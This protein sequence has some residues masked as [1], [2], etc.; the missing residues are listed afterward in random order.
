MENRIRAL[1]LLAIASLV[2]CDQ[3]VVE[4]NTTTEQ[5]AHGDEPTL[6]ATPAIPCDPDDGGLTLPGGFCAVVVHD[7]TT[8]A[9]DPAQA[10]HIVVTPNGDVF[11]ALQSDG[12][13]V[14]ALRDTD[15]DGKAD[16]TALFGSGPGHGLAYHEPYL[17]FAPN[18]RVE[19]YLLSSESLTPVSGPEVIVSEMPDTGD[20]VTK[21]IAV[22]DHGSLFVNLGS[23]SD[24]CQEVNRQPA[25]I[26]VDPCPE[27]PTRSGIWRYDA[28][29]PG[30]VHSPDNRYLTGTR[31]I[32]A[33]ALNPSDGGLYGVQHGRDNL[34]A[35]W[36][37]LFSPQD[38]AELPAEEFFH[39]E[40]GADYGWPY[41]Y[42]D[43]REGV[44]V[45]GPE[46]GGDGTEVGRC[47]DTEDPILTFPAH[48][49]PNGLLFYSGDQFPGR[50]R[51]GA[52][53]AFHGGFNR[54][55]P[56]RDEGYSVHFVQ[57]GGGG[58][59]QGSEVFA[60]GFI[61]EGAVTLPDDAAH[62]PV[63]L[64]E[65]P[66]GSLYVTDDVGGRIWRVL[67][68]QAHGERHGNGNGSH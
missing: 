51:G 33:L 12:G 14:L 34:N 67:H 36:P 62:R 19:R 57:F 61:G 29:Q 44:K 59:A 48:W 30:Q 41:C 64:A 22:T 18:D 32:V 8:P 52:F 28:N 37:E 40:A 21:S 23:A 49:A 65:G 4:P 53:V 47:A 60:E 11:V 58:P 66:D 35:Y 10:R 27:L 7:A 3:T 25:T 24:V 1:A 9:G 42:Y 38:Q 56:F 17:Y 46:Y 6:A 13:G 15:G 63:G 31:N 5:N 45:L 20:H 39:F 55:D 16:E 68:A 54:P 50:Y 43:G 2:G 26:G